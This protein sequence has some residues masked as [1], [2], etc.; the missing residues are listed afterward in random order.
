MVINDV[1]DVHLDKIDHPTRPLPSG[2][3]TIHEAVI[4]IVG[5][6]GAV[7]YLSIT[8]LRADLH[9]IIHISTAIIII[10]TPILKR[11]PFIKNIACASLVTLSL[12]FTGLSSST[13]VITNQPHFPLLCLSMSTVFFGSLYNEIVL[14]M[15]DMEGDRVHRIYTLPVLCGLPLS[16]VFLCFIVYLNLEWNFLSMYY[17][18]GIPKAMGYLLTYSPL[19]IQVRNVYQQKYS[20]ES[21][22]QASKASSLPL[23]FVMLYF[24]ILTVG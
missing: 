14:D 13:M 4:T 9:W 15:R 16:F 5:F 12:F 22:I 21:L 8:Y 6:L 11:L 24:C 17:L 1:Y 20:K 18:L 23:L 10:Y 2:I 7:E 19:F 3:I